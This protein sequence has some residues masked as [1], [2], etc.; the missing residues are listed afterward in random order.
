[1]AVQWK[2]VCTDGGVIM[3]KKCLICADVKCNI[4][5]TCHK[6]MSYC[7]VKGSNDSLWPDLNKSADHST[8]DSPHHDCSS[9]L[10][11][12]A[13]FQTVESTRALLIHSTS[14][15]FPTQS[16]NQM[17]TQALVVVWRGKKHEKMV[18]NCTR[19]TLEIMV[20]IDGRIV[21]RT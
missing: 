7:T 12:T 8:V 3:S 6:V 11:H 13:L 9:I 5:F 18:S 16:V 1:M 17:E 10:L 2:L 15:L 21:Q 14:I 20:G 4:V 19:M